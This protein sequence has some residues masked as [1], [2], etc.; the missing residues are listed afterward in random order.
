MEHADGAQGL[1]RTCDSFDGAQVAQLTEE[2]YAHARA[3]SC[4]PDIGA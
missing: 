3:E 2:A 1:A 4:T